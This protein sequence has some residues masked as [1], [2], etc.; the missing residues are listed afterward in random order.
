MPFRYDQYHPALT[1]TIAARIANQGAIEAQRAQSV[2]NAWAGAIQNIGQS[3]A[4]IPGQMLVAKRAGLQDQLLAGQVADAQQARQGG[5]TV[6]AM[7]RGDQLPAGDT[8]PRQ[9]GYLAPDGLFDIGKMTQA[10]G[11]SGMGHLAPDLL[12]GAE[13]INDSILKHQQTEA[14][15]AKDH[16]I[17]IGDLADGALK[18]HQGVG[19]PLDAAMDFVVQPAL[20]TKRISPDD[21]AKVKAQ[22]AS[23]PPEQ[24]V[25]ALGQLMHQAA[26]LAP[27]KTL[28]KDTQEVDRYGRVTASNVVPEKP[29]EASIALDAAKGNPDA[30]AAMKLL[31]PPTPQTEEQDKARYR[32]IQTRLTQK[33]PVTAME[34][35]WASAFEKEKKLTVDATASAAADRQANAIN[36]STAQQKRAQDFQQLQAARADIQK[37]VDTPF[38][39]ART[40]ADTLR[41]VVAAAK[42]GNKVAGSLQSL[43]TTMAAIRAQGLNRVNTAEI[44]ATG[45]AGSLWDHISS[46]IGK[47]AEGQP[48]PADI[49]K[50]M[51]EF[52]D[53]LDKAAVK[54]YTDA[55]DA[56]NALYGTKIPKTFQQTSPADGQQAANH[57]PKEGTE[58][59]VNGV[60]A[61]WKTVNGKAG[62][63]RK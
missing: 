58:G 9:Q 39:T 32:D 44:G 50:D 60:A 16:A 24:Q 28:G 13:S 2:G 57:A 30:T 49:Q 52:A 12:K 34:Q 20:A 45:D 23:L 40:S 3:V 6:D 17:L 27:N 14:Q 8:G 51:I 26:Q 18:L 37:N 41:D 4:Q 7:M 5:A 22:I 63:Y 43:E 47:K 54:K 25:A 36:Q 62:W 56:V 15:L 46:Y 53:I 48:V 1:D 55:H 61:V 31:K 21:Y 10:L 33:Q 59:V 42:A 38:L 35:A 19:M 29:T 11:A